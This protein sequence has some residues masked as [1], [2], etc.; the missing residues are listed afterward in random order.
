MG[1]KNKRSTN[2]SHGSAGQVVC[3]AYGRTRL[4]GRLQNRRRFVI[5]R[6]RNHI[7]RYYSDPYSPPPQKRHKH[8]PD[9]IQ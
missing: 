1:T 5:A 3:E 6:G 9:I 4:T 7:A 8:A 2:M